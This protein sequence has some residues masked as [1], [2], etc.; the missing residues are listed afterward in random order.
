MRIAILGTGTVGQTI[1]TK[2]V[3]IGHEI[4]MGS[5]EAANPKAI[6]WA[7]KENQHKD[8]TQKHALFGTFANAA[9]FG[10]V[11]FNCTLGIASLDALHQAKAENLRGKIIIDTANPLD[12]STD[13]WSLTITSD[14]SLGEQIQHA[15]PDSF[16]VKTLNTINCDVMVNP[17]K[18]SEMTDIFLSGDS[19]A[20]K[21]RVAS[22]M[23]EWFGWRSIIDLGDITTSRA[24]EMYI[25][26]WRC[27][28]KMSKSYHFNIKLVG[29]S[30]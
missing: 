10:E 19:A 24:V 21:A 22:Y 30:Q 4:Y 20:A 5:R 6:T 26:L 28:R 11:V 17:N 25:P 1:G 3:Q 13:A 27:F 8:S 2:L 18:L 9:A 23:R 29:T 15:F 14:D 16:V 12:Y 7:N